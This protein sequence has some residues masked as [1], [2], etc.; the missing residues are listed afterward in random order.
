KNVS[1]VAK[2]AMG[3][4]CVRVVF[5]G[6]CSLFLMIAAGAAAAVASQDGLRPSQSREVVPSADGY[7]CSMHPEIRTAKPG[8]CPRCGMTLVPVSPDNPD[9]FDLEMDV[10]P[11]APRPNEPVR[12]RFVLFNPKTGRQA[13]DF[14]ITHEKLF[15]LFLVSQDLNDFQHI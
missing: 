14:Q 1:G 15:H 8:K 12:L 4:D 6:F 3:R 5:L 11:R 13:K 10:T 9:S 7:T 2:A